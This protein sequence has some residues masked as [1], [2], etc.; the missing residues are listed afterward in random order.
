MEESLLGDMC[1]TQLLDPVV[2]NDAVRFMSLQVVPRIVA[3]TLRY[4]KDRLLWN[5]CVMVLRIYL[6]DTKLGG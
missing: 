1:L 2:A 4:Y 6:V 5:F 3:P